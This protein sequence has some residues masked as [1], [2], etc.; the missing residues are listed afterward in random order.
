MKV[1]FLISNCLQKFQ[2]CLFAFVWHVWNNVGQLLILLVRWKIAGKKFFGCIVTCINNV[3]Q[4]CK[5][6]TK[7]AGFHFLLYTYCFCQSSNLV[8]LPKGLLLFWL[9]LC[10]VLFDWHPYLTS[11]VICIYF[12]KKILLTKFL[13]DICI[14]T[15]LKNV[16]IAK[17]FLLLQSL[18]VY[19]V[20]HFFCRI[21]AFGMIKLPRKRGDKDF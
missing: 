18:Y 10:A 1:A 8:P 13:I 20:T 2:K 15:I 9:C 5:I 12:F 7:F 4:C 3:K 21:Y 11:F 6:W 14:Q 19:I 16:M 17:L